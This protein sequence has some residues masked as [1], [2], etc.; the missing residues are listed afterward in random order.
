MNK[1]FWELWIEDDKVMGDD[2]QKYIKSKKIKIETEKEELI[3]GHLDKA[4]HNLKFVKST[5][6]LKEFNDWAIVS[7]YY[8][9]YHASLAL[10][11]LKG[12]STKDHSA[13]LLILIKEFYIKHLSKEEIDIVGN[14][15]IEKEEVLHYVEARNKRSRASYSTDIVFDKN[16]AEKLRLKAISFVNTV[17]NIIDTS[18]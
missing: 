9:I 1:D 5:L 16:E 15:S 11:A 14:S 10:C 3:K 6:E 12:Y 4:D 8:S 2:F 17:K 13:T 7:A 18:T